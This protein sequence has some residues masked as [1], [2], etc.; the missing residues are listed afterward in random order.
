MTFHEAVLWCA[1]HSAVIRFTWNESGSYGKFTLTLPSGECWSG[2]YHPNSFDS[3]F[4][5]QVECF[6]AYLAKGS[7][8]EVS[9]KYIDRARRLEM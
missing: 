8:L 6:V 7:S 3:M 2:T 1:K 5:Y 4:P 9:L